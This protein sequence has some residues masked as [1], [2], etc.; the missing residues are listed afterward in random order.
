MVPKASYVGA[1]T[2]SQ[3]TTDLANDC[4]ISE[5]RVPGKENWW[6]RWLFRYQGNS[7]SVILLPYT[8][9]DKCLKGY[10]TLISE[11][12]GDSCTIS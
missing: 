6:P 9:H 10:Y 7:L 5:G 2:S 12:L 4:G 11:D 8:I 1:E 3:S